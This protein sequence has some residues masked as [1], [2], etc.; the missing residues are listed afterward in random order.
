MARTVV[1]LTALKIDKAKPKEKNYS[2]FDGNGL[3]LLV[4][5]SGSK[6]WRFKYRINNTPKLM[7][8][9]RYPENSLP[10]ARKQHLAAREQ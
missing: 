9:G 6:L 7:S 8:F 10:E 5:A 3:Y 4:K 1:P 2:L